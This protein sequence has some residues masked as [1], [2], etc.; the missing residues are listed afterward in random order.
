MYSN[1]NGLKKPLLALA[2]VKTI[3]LETKIS[4]TVFG[5]FIRYWEVK[6][7]AKCEDSSMKNQQ[8]D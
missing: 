1:D 3:L 2:L 6:G 8:D 5:C 7:R 4:N